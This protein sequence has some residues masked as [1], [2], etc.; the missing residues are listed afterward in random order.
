MPARS[1]ASGCPLLHFPAVMTVLTA[2]ASPLVLALLRSLGLKPGALELAVDPHDEMLG[3]L[4][5]AQR[6]DGD[7]ALCAYFLSGA[8][9]AGALGQVLR[10]RFGEPGRVRRLLDFASGYG[11][12]TRFL[13]GLVPA[14]RLWVSDI[15]AAAVRFQERSFGVH[16]VVS[17]ARPEDLPLPGSFDAILVTSLFTHLPAERFVSWLRVLL[18]LLTPEGVLAFSVHGEDVLPAGVTLP[19]SGLLFQEISESGS[20]PTGDYG[21]TWV[22]ETF[23]RSAVARAATDT[24]PSVLRLRLGICNYQDLY[25]VVP[26]AGA[27]FARL[28]FRYEP[29]LALEQCTLPSSRQLVISG[30][31]ATLANAAPRTVHVRLDGQLVGSFPVD[32]VRP[33]VAAVLREPRFSRSGWGGVVALPSPRSHRIPLA[34]SV[35]DE[36]GAESLVQVSSLDA[37]MADCAGR[38]LGFVQQQLAEEGRRLASAELETAALQARIAAMEASRFWKLRNRW[39]ALKRWLR[40]TDE[41]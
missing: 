30:W 41:R 18:G 11:R 5:E 7:R 4:E 21:S 12:V 17:T 13:V 23:V 6:G 8:S 36:R 25:V 33:D 19:E 32:G 2:E 31:C 22:S 39:F 15:D 26:E 40:W 14:E 38:N 28:D 24:P 1:P 9:I 34:L 27:D 3:F 10:W 16:G 35:E 37:A 20:L 29:Y